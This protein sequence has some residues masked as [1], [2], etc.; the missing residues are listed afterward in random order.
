MKKK[1]KEGDLCQ[2]CRRSPLKWDECWN[3]EEGFSHH[4]CFDDSCY[5]ADPEP[6]VRCDVCRGKGGYLR[7]AARCWENP[8]NDGIVADDYEFEP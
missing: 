1:P 2:A 3:C 7:C 4:D 6:N 8:K 5:C